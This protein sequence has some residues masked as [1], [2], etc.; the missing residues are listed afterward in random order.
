MKPPGGPDQALR[1]AVLRRLSALDRIASASAAES[2]LIPLAGAELARLADGWRLLLTTHRPDRDRGCTA[3]PRS[4]WRRRGPCRIWLM[5]YQH[6]VDETIPGQRHHFLP[7]R[8]Q[9]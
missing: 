2:A 7:R 3:C 8:R 9:H 4:L 5:A 6:L 1:E